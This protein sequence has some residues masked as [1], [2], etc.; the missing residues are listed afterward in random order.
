MP[1]ARLTNEAVETFVRALTDLY[2]P[3]IARLSWRGLSAPLPII[4]EWDLVPGSASASCFLPAPLADGLGSVLDATWPRV[5]REVVDQPSS[6]PEPS[7][8]KGGTAHFKEAGLFAFR[9]KGG[10]DWL[11]TLLEI[12][13]LLKDSEQAQVQIQMRPV[14]PDWMAAADSAYQQLRKTGIWPRRFEL[15]AS[16]IAEVLAYGVATIVLNVQ[17]LINELLTGDQTEPEPARARVDA[18]LQA[19]SP[20]TRHKIH[21]PAMDVTIRLWVASREEGRR[22]TLWRALVNALRALDGDN[23]WLVKLPHSPKRWWKRV[24]N[25]QPPRGKLAPD[26]CGIEE[27]AT[28]L[29]LPSPALQ[30]EYHVQRQP[31]RE[32]PFQQ[33]APAKGIPLGVQHF[34]GAESPVVMP[35]DDVDEACLPHVVIGRMGTGKTMG[36]GGNW[37]AHAVAQGYSVIAVDVEKDQLGDEIAYGAKALGVPEEKIIRLRFGQHP[38]RLDWPEA[39]GA[40]RSAN[41]VANEILNFFNLHDAGAG[42]ETARYIRLAAKTIALTGGSLADMLRLYQDEDFRR[43]T[44][45]KISR[46]DLLAG[47]RTFEALSGGM[48]G[49]VL[50]PVFN[51]FEM[52]LGDDYLLECMGA[53]A[54]SRINF[55]DW[56]TGGYAVLI[57]L[58]QQDLS[59]EAV[60][61]LADLLMSKVEIAMRTRPEADQQPCYLIMDE[62]H[63]FVSAAARWERM[64][65]ETRKW[66]LGL[67]WLFHDWHQLPQGL[68]RA[69]KSAGPHY[70]LYTSSKATYR[71]LAEEI[72][73]FTLEDALQTPRYWAINS[74]QTGGRTL[75]PFLAEMAAPPSVHFS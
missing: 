21:S 17:A 48:K 67:V 22:E 55:L 70:H 68:Q 15:S 69:I 35:L 12:T 7:Q 37:G 75:P 23:R 54:D 52:L 31:L 10:G 13:R 66:R 34:R 20:A 43:N 39:Q 14:N 16:T 61:I 38:I 65:V 2:T 26:Y 3:P 44:V 40:P 45:A 24:I 25:R 50:D 74:I 53:P 33:T 59:H 46:S 41:R 36:F 42:I 30:Q 64:V 27:L 19:L 9:V 72:E 1:D 5:T 62:P 47:W 29:V 18:R 56:M 28:L 11:R 71:D 8:I 4:W 58:P 32:E 6:F 63:Q 57:H 51:R 60:D 73:P 49:K